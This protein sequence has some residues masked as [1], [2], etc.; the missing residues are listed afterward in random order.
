LAVLANEDRFMVR[1]MSP[2]SV[3]TTPVPSTTSTVRT[4]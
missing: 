2:G 4:G 1:F 3:R